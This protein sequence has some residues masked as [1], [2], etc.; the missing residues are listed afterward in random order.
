MLLSD[1]VTVPVDPV[2]KVPLTVAEAFETRSK[3][4]AKTTTGAKANRN[5]PYVISR[6]LPYYKS[7]RLPGTTLDPGANRFTS[8]L[9]WPVC[10]A[11]GA[12]SS[13]V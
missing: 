12:L 6:F 4:P 8:R 1:T 10:H 9:P 2:S 5:F 13:T 3:L 11:G 7:R